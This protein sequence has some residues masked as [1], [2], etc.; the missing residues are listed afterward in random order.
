MKILGLARSEAMSRGWAS[1]TLLQRV[2]G[3]G[4][5]EAHRLLDALSDE[6]TLAPGD[7]GSPRVLAKDACPYT[8]AHTVHFC[9]YEGCRES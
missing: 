9:G 3:V 8:H 7:D 2:L 6:G 5:A 4:F 1:V